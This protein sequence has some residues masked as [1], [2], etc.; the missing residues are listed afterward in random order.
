MAAMSMN[1]VIH[2]AV[3]RDLQR[4]L[5]ATAGFRAGDT[6]RAAALGR[7]WDN[8]EA[9]LTVHH[10]GEHEIAWP[11]LEQ[12]GVPRTV[13]DAL[14]SEHDA[15]AVALAAIGPQMKLFGSSGSAED[16]ASVHRLLQDLQKA[17]VFHL[18]HEEDATEQIYQDN[19]D[20]PVIKEMGRKFGRVS[21]PVAGRFFAWVADGADAEQKAAMAATVPKPVLMIIG[22][23]FGRGYRRDIAPIWNS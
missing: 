1:K 19:V 12:V 10:E 17:T 9:Q 14:D 2:G 13:L 15:M 18:D 5:D 6:A 22:G 8:F 3:R 20:S 21:P 4:F 11:A 16:A 7:A 23:I